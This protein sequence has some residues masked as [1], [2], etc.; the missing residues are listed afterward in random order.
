MAKC[1]RSEV[2]SALMMRR[3]RAANLTAGV[4]PLREDSRPRCIAR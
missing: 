4:A 1:A 2:R 3:A